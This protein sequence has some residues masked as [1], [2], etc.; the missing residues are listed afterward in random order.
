LDTKKKSLGASE[1]DDKQR[2]QFRERLASR[3]AKDFVIIDESGTNLNLTPRSARAPRGQRA[4]GSVPR[5]TP[6]NTTLIASLTL[7]GMGAAMVLEGATDTAAFEV[8]IKH[9]LLPQLQ[10]G[11]IVVMDNL[12]AHKSQRVQEVIEGR[13]CEVWF[14]P[15]Y[16]PDLSPIELAFSKLK[17]WVRRAKARTKEALEEAIACALD[18]V[19]ASDARGYFNHC[20][21]RIGTHVAQ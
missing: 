9:F 10:S 3:D 5:N 6:P 12:S 11:Q 8:Y 19:S 13:G 2:A 7:E 17:E 15:S 14:L 1:R 18:A 16:S 20:G 21:Y 4:Y